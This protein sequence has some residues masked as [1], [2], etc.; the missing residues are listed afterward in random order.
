MKGFFLANLA[1]S[2]F[3]LFSARIIK[4]PDDASN[5]RTT[6]NCVAAYVGFSYLELIFSSF[7]DMGNK[8][9]INHNKRLLLRSSTP[10]RKNIRVLSTTNLDKLKDNKILCPCFRTFFDSSFP[11]LNSPLSRMVFVMRQENCDTK[12]NFK[13]EVK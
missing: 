6:E 11:F 7:Y 10:A 2:T 5:E 13:F 12:Y 9:E 3:D 1:R 4:C 8:E